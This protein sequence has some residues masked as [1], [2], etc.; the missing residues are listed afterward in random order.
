MRTV[1]RFLWGSFRVVLKVA[2]EEV[3][4]GQSR[5]DI[6]QQERGWKLF[7]LLPRM[8][9]HRSPRGGPISRDKL[10]GRFD[11]PPVSGIIC[12]S[13]VRHVRRRLRQHTHAASAEIRMT[14]PIGRGFCNL[15][16]GASCHLADKPSKELNWRPGTGA[17]WT[18]CGVDPTHPGM[19]FPSCQRV[20]QC[21]IWTREHSVAMCVPPEEEQQVAHLE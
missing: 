21:S 1:P 16:S 5:R 4:S 19:Q 18:S 11:Q 12:W 8:L 14:E 2:L 3:L 6:A 9:L 15:F 7:L 17:R 13:P 20:R 10:I